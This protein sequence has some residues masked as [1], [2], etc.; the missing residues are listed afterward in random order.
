MVLLACN[1]RLFA[2]IAVHRLTNHVL[3][4]KEAAPKFLRVQDILLVR[5]A[6][7]SWMNVRQDGLACKANA[8][9]HHVA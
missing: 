6:T 1:M 3:A 7:P 9:D 2:P 8:E 5:Y 4:A